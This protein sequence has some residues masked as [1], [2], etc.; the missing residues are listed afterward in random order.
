MCGGSD[1][2]RAGCGQV[3]GQ[4]SDSVGDSW[5]GRFLI[6]AEAAA[7][8]ATQSRYFGSHFWN[9]KQESVSSALSVF[10]WSI[11]GNISL[12][13]EPSRIDSVVSN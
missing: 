10:L 13:A 3:W 4:L 1:L 11:S 5:L 7:I 2:Q 12:L 8:L 6:V 9:L